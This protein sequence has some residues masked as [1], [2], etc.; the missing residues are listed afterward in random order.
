MDFFN[1]GRTIKL[2]VRI[3]YTSKAYSF[4]QTPKSEL[5]MPF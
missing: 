4:Y 3:N 2:I 1:Q 5:E